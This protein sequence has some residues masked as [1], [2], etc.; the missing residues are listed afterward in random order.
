MIRLLIAGVM[1]LMADN[2]NAM[3][4]GGL[5]KFCKPFADSGF[6][7]S[8]GSDWACLGYFFGVG[9]TAHITKCTFNGIG[10]VHNKETINAVIQDYVN[11]TQNNPKEWETVAVLDVI[12]SM[13]EINGL[14]CPT[15]NDF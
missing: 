10:G 8:D 12:A 7:I 13:I 9:E 15:N 5:Y 4:N 14:D 1:V 2:A 6:E 3:S 11:K